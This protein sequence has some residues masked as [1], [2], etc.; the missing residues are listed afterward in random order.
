[1]QL[2]RVT[3]QY[4]STQ[5][6]FRL[7]GGTP[8]GNTLELW[9]TQRLFIRL[10]RV[11][12]AWLEEGHDVS[13]TTA[14]KPED[15]QVKSSLQNFAQQTASATMEQTAPVEAQPETRSYLLNELDIRQGEELVALVFKLPEQE[16]AEFAFDAT[17]LRQWLTIVM[18]QWLEAEWPIGVWPDWM[19]QAAEETT[20]DSTSIAFH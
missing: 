13:T 20:S 17:Q 3:T 2:S 14:S 4:D 11:L 6:R 1:M 15:P 7:L 19:R 12:F 18:K 9:L 10:L 8:D 16:V 5:D